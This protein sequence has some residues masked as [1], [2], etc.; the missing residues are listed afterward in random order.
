MEFH[1]IQ[2]PVLVC[3]RSRNGFGYIFTNIG[4][5]WHAGNHGRRIHLEAGRC[6]VADFFGI[7][8]GGSLN[9]VGPDLA[10]RPVNRGCNFLPGIP[11]NRYS[12]DVHPG[13]PLRGTII[14]EFHFI[15]VPVS[16]FYHRR[17]GFGYIFTNIGRRW[18]ADNFG[19]FYCRETGFIAVTVFGFIGDD[20]LNYVG[21]PRRWRPINFGRI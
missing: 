20:S 3:Y 9:L 16:V 5:R 4:R 12:T 17:N 13:S 7:I 11:G 8:G 6:A 10:R 14:L 21:P 1:F 2:V 18:H 15:Q 19:W